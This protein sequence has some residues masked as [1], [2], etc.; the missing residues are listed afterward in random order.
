MLSTPSSTGALTKYS[1]Q[2]ATDSINQYAASYNEEV[3]EGLGFEWFQY[4]G[5]I[6]DTTRP[7]C[8]ALVGQRY[9][10]KSELSRAAQGQLRVGTVSRAGMY[11]DTTG[12]NITVLRGG[13][14]CKHQFRGVATKNV[15]LSVRAQVTGVSKKE[16]AQIKR[17][18]AQTKLNISTDRSVYKGKD[19][20]FNK[21]TLREESI[22]SKEKYVKRL[23]RDNPAAYYGDTPE[24]YKKL[25]QELG[26]D[27]KDIYINGK[28]VYNGNTSPTYQINI[29]DT[30]EE[31]RPPRALMELMARGDKG[32][33]P[34]VVNLLNKDQNVYG[35]VI[36]NGAFYSPSENSI[37]LNTVGR[38]WRNGVLHRQKV[39]THEYAHA[40]AKNIGLEY[41]D[42]PMIK[43]RN[44]KG[45][46]YLTKSL[47]KIY[48][49]NDITKEYGDK[50]FNYIKKHKGGF[51]SLNALDKHIGVHNTL[52]SRKANFDVRDTLI[53][54]LRNRLSLPGGRGYTTEDITE[55][56]ATMSDLVSA[57]TKGRNGY[58]HGKTYFME[59][60][61][62]S[63][64]FRNKHYYSLKSKNNLN[65][66]EFI[67]ESS[68]YVFSGG[69][70]VID[71]YFPELGDIF[72]DYWAQVLTTYNP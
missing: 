1:G 47:S 15:P 62:Q 21:G 70:S 52:T 34:F 46:E 27:F 43:V 30:V 39:I 45:E 56:L 2:I 65:Y 64:S 37:N 63:E 60:E 33:K 12:A 72:I 8:K 68:E 26:G 57:A 71:L 35:R 25:G 48:M 50:A 61:G 42:Y 59:L 20:R 22:G 69:N 66:S 54:D 32:G 10:H 13:Y 11:V 17:I 58:G 51:S 44:Y 53:H 31:L 7:F 38:R 18:E 67:A 40:V 16:Q 3:T 36:E 41:E 23:E 24:A 29:G 9:I 5:S 55:E 19:L 6:R 28:M 49:P 14:N 4:V